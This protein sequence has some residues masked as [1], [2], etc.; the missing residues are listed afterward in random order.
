MRWIAE[1]ILWYIEM[2]MSDIKEILECDINSVIHEYNSKTFD[3]LSEKIKCLSEATG[4]KLF[5]SE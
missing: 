2:G 1:D 3:K 4:I 5:I